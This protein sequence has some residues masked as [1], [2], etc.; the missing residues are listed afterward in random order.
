MKQTKPVVIISLLLLFSFWLL[1][2][3]WPPRERGA[4]RTLPPFRTVSTSHQSPIEITD[5]PPGKNPPTTPAGAVSLNQQRALILNGPFGKMPIRDL[6]RALKDTPGGPET[7]LI[8]QALA[9][10]KEEA[11]PLIKDRLT[12]GEMWE[13]HMLTKFLR[14]SP[15]P[16]TKDALVA[17]ARSET[18]HWLPRQDAVFALGS[19]GDRSVGP[20]VLAVLNSLNP[21]LNLQ[22][23]AV[24]TLARIGFKEAIPAIAPLSQA[25]NIH[26]RLFATRSLAELGES[27]DTDFLLSSLRN[28]DYVVRQ[29]ASET[30]WKVDGPDAMDALRA[31]AK[32]D[33]NEAVR[34]GASQA[35][36]KREMDGHDSSTKVEILRKTLD[37]VERLTALWILRTAV[38]DL[39]IEGQSFVEGIATRADFLGERARAYLIFASSGK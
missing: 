6:L 8:F 13:K 29:E 28:K 4:G 5:S 36:L 33:F 12:T 22:M 35:I 18:E 16:E 9:L 39:G 32:E 7:Q 31:I 3:Q 23:A 37:G 25:E 21:P 1:F 24:S 2:T 10:R 19:L 26:L 20:D 27:V 38:Y 15:W 34:D 17:L 11:L 14:L 30:L